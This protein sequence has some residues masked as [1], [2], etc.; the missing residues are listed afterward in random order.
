MN[1]YE[2]FKKATLKA[3]T[4]VITTHLMPDAD[5]LGSAVALALALETQGKKVT[6]VNEESLLSRYAYLDPDK[7]IIS[8]DEYLLNQNNTL[9]DLLIVVDT[10]SLH[11]TGEK[12]QKFASGIPEILYID[13][14]P[15]SKDVMLKHCIDT[16]KA[17]TGELVGELIRSIGVSLNYEMAL[18]LY[19]AILI[20]TSSF[21]YPTVSGNTHRLIG[22]LMDA[23]VAP[24]HAYNKIYGTKKITYMK[25]LGEV[26]SSANAT[27]NGEIAWIILRE[28]K[29][30][31]FN[32][33]HEDTHAFINNLLILDNIQVAI[34]FKEMG[35]TVKVS[36][37]SLG[38]VDVG[39][40]A[41]V[42]GGGGHDHSAATLI[43]GDIND[44]VQRTISTVQDCLKTLE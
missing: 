11:R 16:T 24:P 33:D 8:V 9:P 35:S 42:L 30:Q 14:H 7:H 44:V 15:C 12:V 4:I 38:I 1:V 23:G 5:G 31:E 41:K 28:K 10:N 21:R 17:A 37:R 34:M 20:D 6:C 36:L 19:T 3:K 26:L 13:H 39:K 2:K 27:P 25:L 29:L 18:P 22:A 40:I 32:V 43:N